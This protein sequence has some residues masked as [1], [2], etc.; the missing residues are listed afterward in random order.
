LDYQEDLDMFNRLYTILAD[1]NQAANIRNVYSV[2]DEDVSIPRMNQH[3]TLT[4]K[5]DVQL[6][7]ELNKA[8]RIP[9]GQTNPGV[10]YKV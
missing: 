3:L 5:T 1:R 8:T 6:I 9:V 2:L 10:Q 7:D 4:Y